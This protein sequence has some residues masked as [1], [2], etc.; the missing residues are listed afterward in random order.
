MR[1]VLVYLPFHIPIYSYGVMLALSLVVGWHLTLTLCE[2]DGMDRQLMGRCYTWT[3]V[4]AVIGARVL[5]V[6]VNFERF[7]SFI[8]I[9]KVW[10][11][12]LVA[13]GGFIG[14]FVGA[15]LFCRLHGIRLLAWADCAVPSLCTGLMITRV[16]CLLFGCD[17]GRPW[18]GP[19]AITFPSTSPAYHQQLEKGLITAAAV[20]SLPVHPTQVYES[21]NGLLLFCLVMIVR[22]Y[23]KFS[24][25]MFV[26]FTMGYAILRYIVEDLRA[27]EQRGG[28]GPFSTSQVIGA[29]TFGAGLLLLAFLVRAWQRDPQS[30]RLWEN[31]R[32]IK[33]V[34]VSSAAPSRRSP[35]STT[36]RRR[37][38]S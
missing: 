18:S 25:E 17:F 15:A 19:W 29:C 38:K 13:Y 6:I 11:G 37:K 3:A 7:D 9:F 21:L 10:Q 24:G 33:T 27:D 1:P 20:R 12:G 23:R 31:G 35:A 32:A 2:R 5:Y 8:D 34:A 16:G 28:I 36:S 4:A 30:M 22:R 26:A 14:G